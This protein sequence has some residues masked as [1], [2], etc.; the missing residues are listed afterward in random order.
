MWCGDGRVWCVWCVW[1]C[2]DVALVWWWWC[3]GV[4]VWVLVG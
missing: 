1:W 3:S 4:V 2:G